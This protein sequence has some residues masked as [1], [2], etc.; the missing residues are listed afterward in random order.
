M[1]FMPDSMEKLLD[2]LGAE[3]RLFDNL[4]SDYALKPGSTIPAPKGIFPR[5][6]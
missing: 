5:I 4:N 6:G 1:P 2:Q 3:N